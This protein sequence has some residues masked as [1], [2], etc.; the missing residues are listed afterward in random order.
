MEF[1]NKQELPKSGLCCSLP[2]TLVC[3]LETAFLGGP[4]G[5][6]W[7]GWESLRDLLSTLPLTPEESG[8]VKRFSLRIR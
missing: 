1:L 4:Q 8:H 3:S 6:S 7:Q 2:T 5:P